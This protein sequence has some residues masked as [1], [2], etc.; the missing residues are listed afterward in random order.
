M[1]RRTVFHLAPAASI[2]R[3]N[4]VL[5][6][7]PWVA[8]ERGAP[9]QNGRRLQSRSRA[10]IRTIERQRIYVR[11][12]VCVCVSACMRELVCARGR[13]WGLVTAYA[14]VAVQRKAK[15]QTHRCCV[16]QLNRLNRRPPTESNFYSRP[17]ASSWLDSL[18]CLS[19]P[20]P[21]FLKVQAQRTGRRKKRPP[22]ACPKRPTSGP[23]VGPIRL[24]RWCQRR[25]PPHCHGSATTRRAEKRFK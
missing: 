1:R 24:R 2:C 20:K 6:L 10:P 18:G 16:S 22:A 17:H 9:N 4:C 5:V 15:L 21:T 13:G 3:T 7:N 12:R 8:R 25:R 23:R 11:A 14:R 19:P